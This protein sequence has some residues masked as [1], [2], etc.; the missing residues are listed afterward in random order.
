VI[1]LQSVFSVSVMLQLVVFCLAALL[2]QASAGGDVLVLS[3]ANFQSQLASKDLALVKFYAPWCGHCK[4][5]APEFEK[6][7]TA[8]K[9]ADPPV[10]LAEVDCTAEGKETCEKFGVSGYPTLK[11]F[12]R[13]EK[14]F[15]YEGPRDADGIVKY[16]KSKAGPSSKLLTSDA[17]VEKFLSNPEH[18]IVGFFE[19]ESSTQSEVFQQL[20]SALSD[21]FRFAHTYSA[22]IRSEYKFNNAIVIFRP[23]RLETKLE[24]STVEYTGDFV[25]GDLKIWIKKNLHGL[26]GHLTTSNGEQFETPLVVVYYDVDYSKNLKGTN[27][28]RNRVMKVAKQFADAGRAVTFAIASA[29]DFQHELTE[30]GLTFDEKP[31]VAGRNADGQKFVMADEFTVERLQAF[32]EQFLDGKLKPYIKSE[33]VPESNDGPVKVVVGSTF[34]EIVNDP[35]KDVL[36]EFYAPWCG[37]CKSLAPK[38]EELAT[39]L[40][41]ETDIVI[42]KMDATANDV[43]KPYEVRGFPTIYYAPKGSKSSPQTFEGGREVDDFI[44][45]LAKE[46]TEPLSGYTRDGKKVKGKK[47]EL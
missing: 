6:A 31:V 3:D 43:P 40:K 34:N 18:S 28:W 33:P 10:T 44:K 37:H 36:I 8:L 17:D 15:D 46:S 22:D 35:T 2:S 42:A 38:Y 14:A 24:P 7:A 41:E 27:Y 32:T 1:N 13:G 29:V 21:D 30:H 4:Q 25:L 12:K 23:Q 16:M 47:T 5:L 20:A 11:A 19:S 39:K 45:F 9:N 26:V